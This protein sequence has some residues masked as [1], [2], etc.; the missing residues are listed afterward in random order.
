MKRYECATC[1]F[2]IEE[3]DVW[4]G[5]VYFVPVF[6]VSDDGSKY[7]C[8]SDKGSQTVFFADRDDLFDKDAI[9]DE[10]QRWQNKGISPV[11]KTVR[12]FT[13]LFSRR[14]QKG[15]NT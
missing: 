12:Y 11:T 7:I 15:K 10:C 13:G 8:C 6:V 14:K 2:L 9:G 3:M 1:L 4:K 5:S